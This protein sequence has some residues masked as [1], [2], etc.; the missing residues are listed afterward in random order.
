MK[1]GRRVRAR[2]SADAPAKAAQRSA[3]FSWSS[4]MAVACAAVRGNPSTITPA[5]YFSSSSDSSTAPTT[6]V[7]LMS[8]PD[9]LSAS[10]AGDEKSDETS[11]ACCRSRSSR[12]VPMFVPLPAPGAPVR[13]MSSRGKTRNSAPPRRA[14]TAAKAA[15]KMAR[16]FE[17][18]SAHVADVADA[19]DAATGVGDGARSADVAV[20]RKRREDAAPP[21]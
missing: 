21:K 15:S 6:S 10:K 12:M 5:A 16:A 18:I 4:T 14:S 19:S 9:D 20:A 11:T 1:R 3:S 2:T 13:K 17:S 7:S 8:R